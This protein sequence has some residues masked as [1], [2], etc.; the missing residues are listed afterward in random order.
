MSNDNFKNI[1]VL[2]N[3]PSNLVDEAIVILK[4]K[5]TARKLELIEKKLLIRYKNNN[6]SEDY[7]VKEAENVVTNYIINIEKNKNKKNV[8]N[9]IETKYKKIKAYSIFISILLFFCMVRIIFWK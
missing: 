2:K 8:C 4:S 6:N 3:L 9:N 1:V 5:K 7:I